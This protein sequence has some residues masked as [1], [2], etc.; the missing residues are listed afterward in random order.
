MFLKEKKDSNGVVTKIKSRLVAGGD[1][2]NREELS[3]TPLL[4]SHLHLS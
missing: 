3:I 4:L 2:Q 1:L